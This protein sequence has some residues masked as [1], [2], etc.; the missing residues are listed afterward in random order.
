MADINPILQFIAESNQQQAGM[1]DQIVTKNAE[2]A[3]SGEREIAAATA[4]SAGD[5]TY[6]SQRM[7]GGL[8]AQ[9]AAQMVAAAFGNNPEDPNVLIG[10]LGQEFRSSTLA[11]LASAEEIRKKDSVSFLDSP[12]EYFTNMFTVNADIRAHNASLSKANTAAAAMKDMNTITIEGAKAQAAISTSL[13]ADSVAAKIAALTAAGQQEVEKI[14]QGNIKYDIDGLKALR[15]GNQIVLANKLA[16][17]NLQERSEDMAL[18]RKEHQL[19]IDQMKLAMDA[20]EEVLA[21]KEAMLTTVNTG[22]GVM[23]KPPL[24][25]AQIKLMEKTPALK[26]ELESYLHAG[27]EKLATGNNQVGIY[28]GY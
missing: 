9:S 14:K 6:E 28:V 8:Q 11:A 5:T 20:K 7:A 1:N 19:R 27:M 24:S 17:I 23:G 12:L 25:Y 22:A 4:K 15:D 13:T 18:R 26:Q 3:A 10:T 16:A 2:G 21:D